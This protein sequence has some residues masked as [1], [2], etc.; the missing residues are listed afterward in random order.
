MWYAYGWLLFSLHTRSFPMKK[1][2]IRRLDL[3]YYS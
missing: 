3:V 1:E 2:T